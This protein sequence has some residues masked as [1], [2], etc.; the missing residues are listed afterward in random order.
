MKEFKTVSDDLGNE[1]KVSL[2]PE[3]IVSLVPS[4]TEL[5][6]YLQLEDVVVGITK[7]CV[8]PKSWF[9]NKQRI[10]GTK[11]IKVPLLLSLKPDL[12]IANKEE[13]VRDQIEEL[14]QQVPVFVTDVNT[15]DD[16]I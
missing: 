2:A 12:V 5:L 8:H 10:G 9:Q 7:F 3:R 4:I 11:N 13:N 14:Q 6:H 15:F 16:A 1:I